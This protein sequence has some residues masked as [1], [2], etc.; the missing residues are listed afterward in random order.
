MLRRQR[1][2]P[3][4]WI[5]LLRVGVGVNPIVGVTWITWRSQR[6]NTHTH[7]LIKHMQTFR[8]KWVWYQFAVTGNMFGHTF[9]VYYHFYISIYLCAHYTPLVSRLITHT[10]VYLDPRIIS[11][12]T[13]WEPPPAP[14]WRSTRT[15]IL[16]IFAEHVA[17]LFI[18]GIHEIWPHLKETLIQN[19]AFQ[20]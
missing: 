12:E 14:M 7:T 13:T 8:L 16:A 17:A 2:F 3:E 11:E 1:I 6:S 9:Q 4:N 19:C 10:L 5:R 20:F 15:Q 18:E